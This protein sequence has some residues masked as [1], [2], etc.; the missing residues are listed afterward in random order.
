VLYTLLVQGLTLE[1]LL[2]RV[3]LAETG[4]PTPHSE[5]SPLVAEKTAGAPNVPEPAPGLAPRARLRAY[6]RKYGLSD[7]D[8]ATYLQ[9]PADELDHL[10]QRLSM[11][12]AGALDDAR[13]A[14]IADETGCNLAR[15]DALLDPSADQPKA[16]DI[17]PVC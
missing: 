7:A 3:G 6:Q 2:R 17:K 1:A 14:R 15:L 5:T 10:I 16:Y 8:L 12:T 13:V 9:I 11:E 4:P